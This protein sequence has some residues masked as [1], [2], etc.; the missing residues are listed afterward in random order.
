MKNAPSPASMRSVLA[1]A[2]QASSFHQT[3]L[4]TLPAAVAAWLP[5]QRKLSWDISAPADG[6]ANRRPAV[7]AANS[8]PSGFLSMAS[9]LFHQQYLFEA[10]RPV[11]F[12][13]LADVKPR[14]RRRA[15]RVP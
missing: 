11:G 15:A 6:G 14:R 2:S 4:R 12:L 13:D 5:R 9:P 1:R 7:A 8:L 3:P 10:D